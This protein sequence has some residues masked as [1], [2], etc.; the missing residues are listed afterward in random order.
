MPSYT[1]IYAPVRTYAPVNSYAPSVTLTSS[2]PRQ[3]DGFGAF[4]AG[5]FGALAIGAAVLGSGNRSGRRR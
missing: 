4:L 5:I 1:Q 3:D 2:P